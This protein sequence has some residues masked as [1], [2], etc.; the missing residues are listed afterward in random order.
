MN[1]SIN[2]LFEDSEMFFDVT[3]PKG[4]EIANQVIIKSGLDS[5]SFFKWGLTDALALTLWDK[6]I[7]LIN[8]FYT[9]KIDG[10]IL[11]DETRRIAT[12]S[13]SLDIQYMVHLRIVNN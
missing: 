9:F 6:R 2:I 7:K 12:I 10:L 8:T 13:D 1:L 3:S 11:S 5:D 4:V